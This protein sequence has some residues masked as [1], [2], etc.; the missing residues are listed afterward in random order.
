M[1]SVY[2]TI[3]TGLGALYLYRMILLDAPAS[4]VG[5]VSD[6]TSAVPAAIPA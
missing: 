2:E 3:L 4:A 1:P 6:D 5:I